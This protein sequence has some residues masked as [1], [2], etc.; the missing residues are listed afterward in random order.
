[1][2]P[3]PILHS[4][5][6]AKVQ[7]GE[8][9]MSMNHIKDRLLKSATID[10]IILQSY[11]YEAPIVHDAVKEFLKTHTQVV[12]R[13]VQLSQFVTFTENLGNCLGRMGSEA[14]FLEHKLAG[15]L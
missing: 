6:V 11:S 5:A 4:Q 2:D 3:I 1:M 15:T 8:G 14:L 13:E 10:A 9:L 12:Q 7:A